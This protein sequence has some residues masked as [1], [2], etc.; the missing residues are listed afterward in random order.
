MIF[1]VVGST[2]GLYKGGSADGTRSL[3][4]EVAPQGREFL[5]IGDKYV[6]S[7]AGY[8]ELLH[9]DR[10]RI[11]ATVSVTVDKGHIEH[12]GEEAMCGSA[13]FYPERKGHL[14]YTPPALEMIVVVDPKLFEELFRLRIEA[15]DAATMNVGIAELEYGWE[16]D[17]SHQIWKLDEGEGRQHS[18]RKPVKSFWISVNTFS[19]T[20]RAIAAEAERKEHEE[21]A[22]S[23][24]PEHRKLAADLAPAPHA[25]TKLLEQ[26]RA[27]LLAILAIGVWIAFRG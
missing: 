22:A 6:V 8:H 16:P 24:D 15:P 21:L 2:I 4:F 23:P 13:S 12:A 20:E 25:S 5:E 3:T 9:N 1:N 10:E 18:Q 27:V 17:G 7:S 26:C 11:A 19:A 14:D